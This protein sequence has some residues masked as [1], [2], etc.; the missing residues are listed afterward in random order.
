MEENR[1]TDG[2]A[3]R[4]YH[5]T[6]MTKMSEFITR[7]QE[8]STAIN[9]QMQAT[10]QKRMEENQSVIA[11]L[12][13]V[14]LLCGKQ[15]LALRDDH[16]SWE[17][18]DDESANEGNFIELVRFRAETDENLKKHLQKA[19]RNA[20]YTSKTIQKQLIDSIGKRIQLDILSEVKEANRSL[21]CKYYLQ[22]SDRLLYMAIGAFFSHGIQGSKFYMT[23][24]TSFSGQ[25]G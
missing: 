22:Q 17:E 11:S 19:P 9:I 15:G 20:R 25:F 14:V 10:A 6:S 1:K 5:L 24:H 7:Y 3:K 2:N 18:E 12:F 21:C 16:I 8:P 4:D 13:K 23:N